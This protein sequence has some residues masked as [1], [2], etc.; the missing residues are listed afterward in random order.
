L[1]QERTNGR[2]DLVEIVVELMIAPGYYAKN[3]LRKRLRVQF[4]VRERHDRIVRA[5][6]QEDPHPFGQPLGEIG[7]RTNLAVAP[8]S[9]A[10]ERR[11]DQHE[12]ARLP[13]PRRLGE[14]VDEERAADRMA[15]QDRVAVEPA[16]LVEQRTLPL[17][18]A[19]IGFAGQSRVGDFGLAAERVREVLDEL[20]VPVVVDLLARALHEQDPGRHALTPSSP[21]SLCRRRTAPRIR[22]GHRKCRHEARGGR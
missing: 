22:N 21:R 2:C 9:S 8:S 7:V 10:D 20:A 13:R 3:R 6:K 4:R 15:D 12:R 11:G 14:C 19:R 18:I 1:R 16:Q 5:M 17:G